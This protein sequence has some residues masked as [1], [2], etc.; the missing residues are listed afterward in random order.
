[1]DEESMMTFQT[2]KKRSFAAAVLLIVTVG[3]VAPFTASSVSAVASISPASQTVSVT[4]GTAIT[5]TT[6]YTATEITGTKSFSI[7]PSLPAGLTMSSTTGVISGTPTVSLSATTYTVTASDGST[8]ATATVSITVSDAS[9]TVVSV[10]PSSQSISGKVGTAIAPTVALTVSQMTG[11][12]SFSITPPLAAGITLNATTGV[13]SGTPSVAASSKIHVIT[14]SNG[15]SYGIS[16]VILAINAVPTL[17]PATQSINGK[18]NTAITPSATLG[19]TQIAGVKVF[20]VSPTLPAG[21]S[22]NSATG[23]ISGTPT[24]AIQATTFTITA[25]DGTTSE[26]ATVTITVLAVSSGT[27]TG[28]LPASIGGALKLVIHPTDSE[29][30]SLDFACAVQVGVRVK[31][32]TVAVSYPG[33]TVNPGVR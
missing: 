2:R 9:A 5:P 26:A 20:T 17:T 31:G 11:T 27:R 29:L 23:V 16:T 6:A 3:F 19:D 21:L 13:I 30:P 10:T 32:I 18:I 25:T 24:V 7:T 22:L 12:K 8:S 1:M 28:C 4:V 33:S 15:S 14:V